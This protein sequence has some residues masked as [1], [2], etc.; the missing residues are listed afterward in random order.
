M[1]STAAVT[2][3]ATNLIRFLDDKQQLRCGQPKKFDANNVPIQADL[4][5]QNDPYGS[6]ELT[7]EMMTVSKLLAPVAPVQI[8][9]I[10][11]NYRRHA[12]ET[13]KDIPR[14]PV[15]FMKSIN[16][17]LDPFDAIRIP[18]IASSPAEVDYEGELAIVMGKDCL[19]VSQDDA[20]RHVLGY[21][22]GNDVSARRWQGKKG[23]GQWGRAKSFDTFCPLGPSLVTTQAITDPGS[24]RIS[25]AVNGETRQDSNTSDMIFS[26]AELVSYLSQ[27]TTLP[28][29]T[30]I[31]TGTPEGVGYTREPPAYL[32]PGDEV[33]ITI[34]GIGSLVNP[35]VAE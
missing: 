29:G 22:V 23:G 28:K 15:L 18:S 19:N 10:G 26:V 25:T 1:N 4:I 6:L 13:K 17:T 32:K 30:V 16:S 21:T 20:L 33:V 35:V 24:L 9:C 7:G 11:L 2:K 14:N 12:A 5:D 3:T 31:L 34:E 8:L 27:S